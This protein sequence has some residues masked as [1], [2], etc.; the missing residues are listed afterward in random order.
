MNNLAQRLT[1]L[2]SAEDFLDF[3]GLPYEQHV[4]NVSRLHILKRFFQY[5]RQEKVQD[6]EDE[7][8]MFRHMRKL[9]ARSYEDFVLSTP[10]REKVFRVHQ[11]ADG[12]R[13]SLESLRDTLRSRH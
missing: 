3:F 9:L 4:L 1:K 8:E 13:V 2:S 6:I 7:T 10:A 11:M 5:M 12:Q